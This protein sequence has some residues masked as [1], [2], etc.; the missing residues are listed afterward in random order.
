MISSGL[1][2]F[3]NQKFQYILIS[4]SE[5]NSVFKLCYNFI[6]SFIDKLTTKSKLFFPLLQINP[7]IRYYRKNKSIFI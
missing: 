1:E 7:G 3:K 6:N 5:D 2:N 4:K